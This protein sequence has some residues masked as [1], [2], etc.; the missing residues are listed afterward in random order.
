M[1]G[2][3]PH[4]LDFGS[5]VEVRTI[6]GRISKFRVTEM[7]AGGLGGSPG[8]FWYDDMQS[9]KIDRPAQNHDV[10]GIVLGV[11]G[12]AALVWIVGNA[13]SVRVCSGTPCPGPEP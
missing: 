8:F 2:Q 9:L 7:N 3:L 6:D 11:L 10:A 5:L 12:V 13:D 4:D 1:R